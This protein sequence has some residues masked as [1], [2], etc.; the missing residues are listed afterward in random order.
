MNRQSLAAIGNNE[1]CEFDLLSGLE[2]CGFVRVGVNFLRSDGVRCIGNRAHCR[3]F[4][5]VTLERVAVRRRF[6]GRAH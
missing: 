6:S 5:P 3:I 4:L 1:G 2:K